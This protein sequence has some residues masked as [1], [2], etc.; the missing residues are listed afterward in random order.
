MTKYK[1]FGPISLERY[2]AQMKELKISYFMQCMDLTNAYNGDVL[3]LD[4]ESRDNARTMMSS[5]IEHCPEGSFEE[6]S[7]TLG[8]VMVSLGHMS[9]QEY[10]DILDAKE[11]SND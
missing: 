10:L 11:I 5:F 3:V 4:D 7:K 6:F 1:G 9:E 8:K 2:I